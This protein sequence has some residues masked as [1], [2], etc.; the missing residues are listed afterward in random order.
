MIANVPLGAFLSG[1]FDSSLIV[2][3]MQKESAKKVN[4]FSIGFNDNNFNEAVYAKEISKILGTNHNEL[5]VSPNLVLDLFPK[6]TEIYDEPYAD[7]SQFPTYIVSKLA[8]EKVTVAISGDA[9]DE[10]FGGYER[11]INFPKRWQKSK[12][13]PNA[14]AKLFINSLDNSSLIYKN[15]F[16]KNINRYGHLFSTNDRHKYYFEQILMSNTSSLLKKNIILELF[17]T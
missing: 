15:S 10:L 8:R 12:F 14:L 13:I 6:M 5:Y 1:G 16:I 4:T 2:A 11:Y 17:L 9:G 3:L 7:P